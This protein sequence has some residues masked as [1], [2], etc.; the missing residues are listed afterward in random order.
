MNLKSTIRLICRACFFV[1]SIG[2]AHAEVFKCLDASGT[3]LYTDIACDTQAGQVPVETAADSG[4]TPVLTAAPAPV[5]APTP[6][7]A[8]VRAKTRIS[9]SAAELPSVAR[10]TA[11]LVRT[12]PAR[13]FER[14]ALTLKA[15]RA[16][17]LAQDAMS[18]QL[19]LAGR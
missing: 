10:D 5:A 7:P 8:P 1:A 3:V 19:K 18:H 15:A 13:Q 17:M 4:T 14:D 9:L 11:P 16:A 2:N 6:V 12:A